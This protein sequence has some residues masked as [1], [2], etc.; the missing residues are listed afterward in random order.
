MEPEDAPLEELDLE[1][2]ETRLEQA[3]QR[4]P[5]H[6]VRP[7]QWAEIEALEDEIARRQKA[8][9]EEE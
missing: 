9:S 7:W 4:L 2:L 5:A 1:E 3:R 6:S 8:A